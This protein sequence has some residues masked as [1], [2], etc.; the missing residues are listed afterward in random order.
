MASQALD[1]QHTN[2]LPSKQKGTN[3]INTFDALALAIQQGATPEALTSIMAL[4]E[5]LQ[6]V[7]AR[8]AFDAAIAAAKSEMPIIMKTRTVDFT[9]KTG[10]RTNYNFEDL[11]SIAEAVTPV[12]SKHGLSYRYRTNQ[13]NGLVSVTCIIAHEDG[14]SEETTLSAGSDTSGN[15]NSIQA[16]GST[17]TY[18]QRYTI[19]AALGLAVADDDDGQAHDKSQKDFINQEQ[20]ATI[21]RLIEE[22]ETDIEQFCRVGKIEALPDMLAKD[23]ENAVRLLE[24]KKAR[25]AR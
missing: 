4:H 7:A 11:A 14:Y 24:Q 13:E 22:T 23:F 3:V 8:K 16:I 9:G 18:L 6:A 17:V 19:K 20:I 25:M 15:K 10:V 5:R 1:I 12:L 2:E 21:R